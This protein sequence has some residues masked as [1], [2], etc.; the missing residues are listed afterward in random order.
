MRVSRTSLTRA[1]A[2]SPSCCGIS[3]ARNAV[4]PDPLP[5]AVVAARAAPALVGSVGAD[6]TRRERTVVTR[7]LVITVA[8][9]VRWLTPGLWARWRTNNPTPDE[10]QQYY[11]H[12][13]RARMPADRRDKWP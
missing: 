6:E 13:M 8:L 2:P 12:A 11:E 1:P 3:P 10:L 4:S 9:I 7:A 5:R